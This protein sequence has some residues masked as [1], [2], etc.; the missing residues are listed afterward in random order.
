[1]GIWKGGKAAVD[2]CGGGLG[3]VKGLLGDVG[4]VMGLA[5]SIVLEMADPGVAIDCVER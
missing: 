2:D 3:G 4:F 1:V 5:R